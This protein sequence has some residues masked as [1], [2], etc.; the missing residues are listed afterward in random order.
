VISL[1]AAGF[2]LGLGFAAQIGPVT[3]LI[4]R[5]VLR[6]GR[7]Y[8]VALAMAT[9]VALVDLLYATV[10]LAGV[11]HFLTHGS[12]EIA[13]GSASAA[14]L[15]VVGARTVWTGV[16]ARTGLELDE[17]V[18]APRSAFVT[19]VAATALNPL[20]IA[21]WT[22]AFPAAVPAA[23]TRSVASGLAV[24]AGVA[25]GT[26][27]WYGGFLTVVAALRGY[28]GARAVRVVDVVIGLGIVGF[29]GFVAYRTAAD[30]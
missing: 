21:L 29:G 4:V 26:L 15:V 6:D 1:A 2:G 14:I 23:A 27:T 30:R 11:G 24:V 8:A 12:I 3:L 17:E 18:V 25:V 20:T 19:A 5:S 16:R 10:G 13:F 28:V 7:A 9:A 22:I